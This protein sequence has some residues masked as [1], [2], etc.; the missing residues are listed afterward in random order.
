MTDDDKK[1][2]DEEKKKDSLEDILRKYGLGNIFGKGYIKDLFDRLGIIDMSDALGKSDDEGGHYNIAVDN[3][4]DYKKIRDLFGEDRIKGDYRIDFRTKINMRTGEAERE[5]IINGEKFDKDGA[6]NFLKENGMDPKILDEA[7][8]RYAPRTFLPEKP[9]REGDEWSPRKGGFDPKGLEDM[10]KN[11]FGGGGGKGLEDIFNQLSGGGGKK[12]PVIDVS[13][14]TMTP[15]AEKKEKIYFAGEDGPIDLEEIGVE[16]NED[17]NELIV[18]NSGINKDKADGELK[19][20]Y[21]KEKNTANIYDDFGVMGNEIDLGDI[22]LPEY[23]ENPKVTLN[24][25][26]LVVK[27]KPLEE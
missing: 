3:E 6:E 25:G 2:E 5:Y 4:E 22:K 8:K 21:D 15:P 19:F 13:K 20:I 7:E 1:K 14:L 10:F 17:S 26:V 11:L 23:E 9:G 18:S 24:N 27:I 16:Y 12:K